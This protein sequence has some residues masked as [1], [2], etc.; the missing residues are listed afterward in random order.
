[1]GTGAA[2][3][4]VFE[5]AVGSG[6]LPSTN[7]LPPPPYA[8]CGRACS[9]LRVALFRLRLAKDLRGGERTVIVSLALSSGAV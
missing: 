6:R 2:T 3:V 8:R 7:N 4:F 9:G 5:A 1:M